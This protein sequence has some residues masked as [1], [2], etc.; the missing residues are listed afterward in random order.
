[1]W[2]SETPESPRLLKDRGGIKVCWAET[3]CKQAGKQG[4]VYGRAWVFM[5]VQGCGGAGVRSGR[6]APAQAAWVLS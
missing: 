4:G 3:H 6:R 2:V 1:M 5:D